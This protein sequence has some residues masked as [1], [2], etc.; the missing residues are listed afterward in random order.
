MTLCNNKQKAIVHIIKN[1]YGITDEEYR[2]LLI[3]NFD[4][5]D[6]TMG[7]SETECEKFIHILNY[8]YN[9]E[10]KYGYDRGVKEC[11][12]Q[13]DIETQFK[14][15]IKNKYN[16]EITELELQMFNSID[17]IDKM[18]LIKSLM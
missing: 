9:Q 4:G 7:L 6:T 13:L 14:I 1:K 3:D 10:Y 12:S 16:R 17:Y 8:K 2:G 5:I 18:N 15:A 11:M